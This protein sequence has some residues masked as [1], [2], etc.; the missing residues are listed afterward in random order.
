M[1]A[2]DEPAFS[3][4][5]T[6]FHGCHLACSRQRGLGQSCGAIY[7]FIRPPTLTPRQFDA[8]AA[9]LLGGLLL[10]ALLGSSRGLA[11]LSFFLYFA[12]F[13]SLFL[14]SKVGGHHTVLLPHLLLYLC[15]CPRLAC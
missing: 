11:L 14:E 13:G 12:V 8:C 10:L 9:G 4:F 1:N 5:Y 15:C 6:W 2:R 7:G 3:R